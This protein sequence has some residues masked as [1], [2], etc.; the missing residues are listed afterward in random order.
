MNTDQLNHRQDRIEAFL[1]TESIDAVWFAR[2]QN[3]TWI[4]GGSNVVDHTASIGVA[5]A[6]YTRNDGFVCITT[7]I[8]AERLRAEELPDEFTVI[9]YEWYEQSLNAA[10]AMYTPTASVA[11]FD[12]PGAKQTAG[13]QLRRPLAASDIQPYQEVSHEVAI[14]IERVA[15]EI[16]PGDTE[17][18]VAAALNA[19][20]AA[21]GINTPVILVGK[22]DR[23]STC[24]HF[25]PTMATIDS[26]VTIS[27]TAERNGRHVSATRTVA[28][29]ESIL[30]RLREH[31]DMAMRVEVTALDATR[32]AARNDGTAADVF[33]AIS[34]AYETLGESD[35]WRQHHQGGATGFMGREWIATPDS[36]EKIESPL[37]YAYNPTVHRAKSEDT[38]L[39][40]D[41]TIEVVSTTDNWPTQRVTSCQSSFG[42]D[43]HKVLDAS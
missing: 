33:D 23:V 21:R 18:E 36:N 10:V 16:E 27:V 43:Q 17:Q 5:A 26:C 25:I 20:H 15:K 6:G 35:E 1:N 11:D 19:T 14:T 29:E 8:E 40:I 38:A 37:A 22:C 24:R 13:D 4:T 2:P 9:S 7:N 42:I 41:D 31:H 30:R 39:L 12:L 3:F 34:D 32:E 28:F